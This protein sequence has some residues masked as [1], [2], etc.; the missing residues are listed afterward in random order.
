MILLFESAQYETEKLRPLLGE[1]FFR[2]ISS[3]HAQ[4]DCVGYYYQ[5][6]AAHSVLIL[7]KVFLNKERVFAGYSPIQLLDLQL[8]NNDTLK[9]QWQQTGKSEFLFRF[10]VWLYQAIKIFCQRHPDTALTESADL[11]HIVQPEGG[12]QL[13]ELEV[14]NSL[15]RFNRDNPSLFTFIKRY[16]TSQR[17]QV[18]W[19]RTVQKKTPLLQ[20]GAPVYVETVN[21][22]K[23]IDSDEELFVLFFSTLQYL[24]KQYGLKTSLNPLY[25]TMSDSAFK[26]LLEGQGT[27]RLKQIRGKYFSDKMRQLWQLLYAFFDRAERTKTQQNFREILMIKDFNIVF[28]DM[29]DKLLVSEKELGK[30]KNHKDG[31]ILDHIYE[32]ASLIVPEDTIYHIGDSKYYREDTDLSG[33]SIFKQYTYARNVIQLNIDLLNQGLLE[34]P[35]HYRDDL[36][37]GYNVTPNFFISAVVEDILDFKND[38]LQIRNE[39]IKGNRHFKDRLFDRDTLLLQAYNINFLY[40]LASYVVQN[41]Q[42]SVRFGEMAK[43]LF[44]S[45]LVEFLNSEYEFYQLIP[46][47]GYTLEAFVTRNFRKLIGKI[48][49]PAQFEIGLLLALKKEYKC[50]NERLKTE[51]IHEAD[52]LQYNLI[53]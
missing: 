1:R 15:L 53:V 23:N 29:I 6:P 51:L 9:K 50:E 46:K 42:D 3:T 44:R 28:E 33:N 10:S 2:E 24:N 11:Q 37:E 12:K 27:K 22:H 52:V 5:A 32:Y 47:Q 21:K 19:S 49:R 4:I 26:K 13:S 40:V 35:L 43:R 18:S 8:T 20:E 38:G 45:K 25:E 17:H 16:N 39:R 36:T 48:Y 41:Q 34:A 31:K 14:I 7:P 30:F